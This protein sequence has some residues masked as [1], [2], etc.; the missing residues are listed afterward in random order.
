VDVLI[1]LL[2]DVGPENVTSI[3]ILANGQGER[4]IS[5]VLTREQIE[6]EGGVGE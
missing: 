1:E 5:R 2:R 3:E 6:S 4:C